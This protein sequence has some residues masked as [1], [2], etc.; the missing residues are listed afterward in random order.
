[1][2][3]KAMT[4]PTD[5]STDPRDAVLR[6]A[7]T[8]MRYL[9]EHGPGIVPHLIDTDDNPGQRL[10]DAI[11]A[12]RASASTVTPAITDDGDYYP[13]TDYERGYADGIASVDTDRLTRA[14][15]SLVSGRTEGP[16]WVRF[17]G[18][19]GDG[20]DAYESFAA[21]LLAALRGSR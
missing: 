16:D 15:R 4:D 19:A 3:G 12:A 5:R 10:R 18:Y 1:M 14:L 17:H 20:L 6:E 2:K 9:D 21:Q 11:D 7:E 13:S 8:V